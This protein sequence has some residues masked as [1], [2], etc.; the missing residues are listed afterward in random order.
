MNKPILDIRDKH[1]SPR[2]L[3]AEL[4]AR[5]EDAGVFT[6]KSKS[7]KPVYS[8]A[9]P[10]PNVTGRLHMG[11]ALNN[12]VQDALIRFKRMDGFDALWIPGTDH[13][14][15]STQ[16]VVKKHLDAAGE[17]FQ[18]LGREAVLERIWEWKEQY[19]GHILKQLRSMGCSA[20]WTITRFTM[21]E[22]LSLAVNTAFKRLYDLGLIYR[23]KYIVNWC[24]VDQTALSDDEVS[25]AEGGEPGFLWHIRYPLA[26]GSSADD[27]SCENSVPEYVTIATTR[28]ET[29]LGDSAV[30]VNPKDERYSALVGRELLLPIVG[31]KIPI[32]ADDYVDR[33]FGSGCLK[34]TPA[35]DPNDFQIG[36][37]HSLPFYNVMNK[38]AS[39]G[40]Q[41]PEEYHGLDR[42]EARERVIA[43]LQEQGLL[44][45]TE[46][47]FTPV[48]RAQRSGAIIEYRLSDQWFVKMKPLAEKALGFADDGSLKLFPNRWEKVYRSWLENTRDWCISRQIWWGHQIPA[49]FNKEDGRILVET[50][51]PEEVL[52]NPDDWKR[53]EDV[54]DTWFSSALWPFSTLG[55]PEQTEDLQRYFPTSTLSTAKDII[56]FWVARMV[57]MSGE[58]LDTSPFAEVYFHPVICDAGGETMSKSKG[59]GIDPIHVIS[60]ASVEELKGPAVE[61]K[62]H[63]MQDTIT[64][65]EEN[66]PDGFPAVGADALRITL[67]SLNSNAQ[68]VQL[69]LDKFE[70]IGKRFVE[71]LWNSGRYVVGILDSQGGADSGEGAETDSSET[72]L[73][74]RWILSRLDHVIGE[75]RNALDGYQFNVAITE[76]QSF[77]WD[78]FC[79]WYL[80]LSKSRISSSSDSSATVAARIEEVFLSV[81]KLYHPFVPFITEELFAQ[82][83]DGASRAGSAQSDRNDTENLGMLAVSSYP[84]ATGHK[85]DAAEATFVRVK[86]FV[87]LIRQMRASANLGTSTKIAAYFKTGDSETADFIGENK[88]LLLRAANLKSLEPS[89]EPDPGWATAARADMELFADLLEHLDLDAEIERNERAL[90]KAGKEAEK[91]QKKLSNPKFLE[92]APAEVQQE[93]REALA[94]AQATRERTQKVLEDLKNRA[95]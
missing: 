9:I 12:S 42:F 49:W 70:N 89:N 36:L 35:H 21:D 69:S 7:E 93:Q 26:D 11:H 4:Y 88:S 3:E 50:E 41:A 13:A 80:E 19:G 1:F 59:N 28:P 5:W 37:R 94:S 78:D 30:A 23:D 25:T 32:I 67:L 27:G 22:G 60:G 56:Y 62:A 18:E 14:G 33:S 10:P 48:G 81:L 44:E 95:G 87:L 66:Y 84:K 76:L 92:N 51:T 43:Q 31:R 63:N 85:D 15:I 38:N 54:L 61:A 29:L 53:E 47:R 90:A 40:D 52:A 58:F 45:R 8:I 2:E 73:E 24:P 6:R 20:D 34:V 16:S 46:E 55:W 68:Q 39:I 74:D 65:I 86:E 77:F 83:H 72:A 64:A 91:A 17:D 79:D 57:M 75:V 82:L 71:K